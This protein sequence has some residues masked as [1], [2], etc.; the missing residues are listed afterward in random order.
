[1][2]KVLTITTMPLIYSTFA[3]LQHRPSHQIDHLFLRREPPN[4]FFSKGASLCTASS[5]SQA[6]ASETFFYDF[7]L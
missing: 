4:P 7:F 6:R 1:M 2:V 5:S 3:Y